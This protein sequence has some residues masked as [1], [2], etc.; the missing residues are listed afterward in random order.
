MIPLLPTPRELHFT[1][2]APIPLTE[3]TGTVE[4]LDPALLA[5]GP[6]T[7][8]LSIEAAP[9]GIARITLT[10]ATDAGLRHARATLAQLR[11][12]TADRS[13]PLHIHDWPAFATRG[14]MLDVSRCK[15]PTLAELERT[16]DLLVSLKFNHLQLY[17]EHTFAYTGH[18]EAWSGWSPITPAEARHLDAYASTRGVA[19][20]A[21]QNC[22][23][24]LTHWLKHPRYAP[25]AETHGDWEFEFFGR[26][27]RR[28]GPFSL[29]PTDLR[30]LGLVRDLLSQLAPCFTSPLINIGCDETFDVGQGRS[31]DE[32]ARRGRPAVYFEFVEHIAG[33]A[34]SLGKR[35]MMWADIA[36]SHPGSLRMMAP[37]ILGLA[38]GYEPDAAFSDWITCLRE[39]GNEAWV[40]PGTSSWRSITGRSSERTA[41]INA[42]AAQGLAAG[43]SGYLITDWGDNGHHQH[44]PIALLGI[45]EAAQASWCGS[46]SGSGGTA[47]GGTG[48]P[49]V[50]VGHQDLLHSISLHAFNDPTTNLA[51]WID[52]LGDLDRPIRSAANI[53]NASALFI[54]LYRPEGRPAIDAPLEAWLA[55]RDRLGALARSRPPMRDALMARELD[56]TLAMARIAVEG[57]IASRAPSSSATAADLARRMH[58]LID[59]HS[60]IWR[61][62]NRPGGLA[63]STK[64]LTAIASRLHPSPES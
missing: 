59:E 20:A 37:D 41:N 49:F 27:F 30:S 35:P 13:P 45:A 10:G 6:E 32:V 52:Q 16:I 61:V 4:S 62:R 48:V 8:T 53:K 26:H 64:V 3:R 36:L 55:C 57:A 63:Q 31:R 60:N 15:V 9:G 25:L 2:G 43:A 40:C 17:T 51:T 14:V 22:F 38:W 50:R 44:W 21:N 39:N 28:S 54:D 46:L 18:E 7:Y 24:H 19:L 56:H 12:A 11:L 58:L 1:G 47:P 5:T 42:A 34:R 33:T 29:C 23:G